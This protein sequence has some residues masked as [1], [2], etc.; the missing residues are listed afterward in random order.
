MDILTEQ[1]AVLFS[2]VVRDL[3]RDNQNPILSAK[4]K[5]GV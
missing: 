2:F 3:L 1:K 4:I 5:T